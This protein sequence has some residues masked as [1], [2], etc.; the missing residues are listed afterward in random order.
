[1]AILDI[2][3]L[4]CGYDGKDI[5]RDVTF[6]ARQGSFLGI[7]GPNGAGK[8]TMFRAITGIL[9]PKSGNIFFRDKDISAFSRY[10]VAKHVSTMPQLLDTPFS[11]TV[12]E[13]VLMG[14]FPHLRR[15]EKPKKHDIDIIE[16][17]LAITDT[18]ELKDRR[19]N[20]ISGGEKQ[21]VILA[22]ALAQEPE[23]L[24]LDEPIAHLDIGHQVHI[25]DLIKK[26]N[27]E[28]NLTVVMILHDL[29][30]AG[31]YCDELILMNEGT[32]YKSGAPYEVLTYE[33][34]EKVYKT[35]VVVKENPISKKP[36]VVLVSNKS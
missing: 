24:L 18:R 5:V 19:I 27:R 20:E 2:Q 16:E 10:E 21:R 1:M 8:T 7:I 11:F 32:I 35:I 4:T 9:K 29:N 30:M 17:S 15:W 31:E 36:H 14:R 13:F 28:K 3:S 25:L 23:L 6:Q 34:I 26:L 12:F 22:Q 33:N